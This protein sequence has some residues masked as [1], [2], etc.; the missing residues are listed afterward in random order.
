LLISRITTDVH[1][2]LKQQGPE[3]ATQA[4]PPLHQKFDAVNAARPGGEQALQ[5]STLQRC[6]AAQKA[7]TTQP[8]VSASPTIHFHV[9]DV[10]KMFQPHLP[11][12]PLPIEPARASA[13]IPAVQTI[14]DNPLLV[15]ANAPM[16][17]AIPLID[18]AAQYSFSDNI[19]NTLQGEGFTSLNQLRLIL[20]QELRDMGLKRG[21]IAVL[22]EAAGIHW[23]AA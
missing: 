4:K 23:A 21:E 1:P 5:I 22:Q 7:A 14:S 20:L 9:P 16:L 18:F 3:R 10:L 8:A 11:H 17:P 15:P 13:A 12:V 2:S 6:A 19:R